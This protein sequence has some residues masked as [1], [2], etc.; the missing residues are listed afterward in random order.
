MA[1][2]TYDG[3]GDIDAEVRAARDRA[4]RAGAWAAEVQQLR[5]RGTALR[6]GV[7]VEV[8]QSGA[9]TSIGV[10]DAAAGRGG[11]AVA[12][13]VLTANEQAQAELRRLVEESAA[14]MFGQGSATTTAVVD[15]V[16]RHTPAADG[17]DDGPGPGRGGAW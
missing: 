13:A 6:G 8:D 16:E 17:P 10:S 11:D 7:T 1:G 3:Y 15:E 4:D 14:A 12:R 9:V 5:A 2:S